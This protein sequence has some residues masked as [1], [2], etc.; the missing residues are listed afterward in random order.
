MPA[1]YPDITVLRS[2]VCVRRKRWQP[3]GLCAPHGLFLVVSESALED[4]TV[5]DNLPFLE[6]L[7]DEA[8]AVVFFELSAPQHLIHLISIYKTPGGFFSF[9][10]LT[11][12]TYSALPMNYRAAKSFQQVYFSLN[13]KK[14]EPQ[15]WL[16]LVA[17]LLC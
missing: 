11:V 6:Y 10:Y 4:K 12:H 3:Q 1:P 9:L 16:S 5:A 8:L 15:I 17:C 7:S 2:Q 13:N 14:R